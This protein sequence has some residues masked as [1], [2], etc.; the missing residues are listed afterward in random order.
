MPL[1]TGKLLLNLS[2]WYINFMF[3]KLLR[4]EIYLSQQIISLTLASI[5]FK[6]KLYSGVSVICLFSLAFILCFFGRE[7]D[8][9]KF[10]GCFFFFV[11]V[12]FQAILPIALING[13]YWQETG[14]RKEERSPNVSPLP[15][16]PPLTKQQR[17]LLSMVELLQVGFTMI[18]ASA[19]WPWLLHYGSTVSSLRH[20]RIWNWEQLPEF[21]HFRVTSY[22]LIALTALLTISLLFFCM[23]SFYLV[24]WYAFSSSGWILKCYTPFASDDICETEILVNFWIR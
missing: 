9:W 5:V 4:F 19:V 23:N 8:L 13:S 14:R 24:T 1:M 10:M 21:A 7:I 15:L 18:T 17:L 11:F 12:C 22:L 2:E 20:S 16:S 3:V 6:N